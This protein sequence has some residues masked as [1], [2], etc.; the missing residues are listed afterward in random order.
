MAKTVSDFLVERLSAWGVRRIYGYPGDGINGVIGALGRADG[1]IQFIQPRHEEAASFM[2]CGH[3][4]FTGEIGVC[5]GTSG[6]GAIHLLTGLY[7]LSD[8]HCLISH[9]AGDRR[10]DC[11]V[12]QIELRL[13]Q[14]GLLLLH[15]GLRHVNSFHRG[16]EPHADPVP[17][18]PAL[19]LVAVK[20]PERDGRQFDLEPA[21][22]PQEARQCLGGP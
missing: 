13:L 17:V 21:A 7:D 2:A 11:R 22:V 9:Y 15:A 16:I 1:K 6:P 3:A 4:K 20:S 14:L 19:Q 5:L 18:E 8:L 10:L 12:L